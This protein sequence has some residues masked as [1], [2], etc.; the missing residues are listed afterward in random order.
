MTADGI[1]QVTGVAATNKILLN[2]CAKPGVLP[3]LSDYGR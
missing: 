1:P 2:K 3:A